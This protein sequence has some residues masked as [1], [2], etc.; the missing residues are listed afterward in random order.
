M[1]M[2]DEYDIAIVGGGMIGASLAVALDPLGLRTVVIETHAADSR[3]QPGYDARST[4]ISAGSRRILEGLGVWA[5]LEGV[6]EPIHRVHVSER[7]RFAFARLDRRDTGEPALGYVIENRRLGAAL[8][9]AISGCRHVEPLVPAR[10]SGIVC[11][12]RRVTLEVVDASGDSCEI[13][14]SLVVGADGARSALRE[15]LGIRARVWDYGQTAVIANVSPARFHEQVAYERFTGSGPIAML[16]MN[17]GRCACVWTLETARAAHVLGLSD[18][19]FREALQAEFGYRLGRLL[20]IGARQGYP[21]ALVRSERLDW[22]G[23][24]AFAGNAAQGLHPIAAQGFNLGL[25]DVAALAEAVAADFDD[26]RRLLDRYVAVRRRDRLAAIGLTDGLVRLFSSPLAGIRGA[27]D[28]GLLGLD[29]LP[30]LKAA[31]ARR[32]MGL[33]GRQSRLARGIPLERAPN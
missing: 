24:V 9:E 10:V 21:L 16:P 33:A 27:R 26:P 6:A 30:P 3:A 7:G 22:G 12:S 31:F 28:L 8:W 18:D 13:T 29:L 23:R 32:A 5:R 14:A 1:D 2:S 20:R 17:E 19:A 11:G 4:A 15:L 25:R